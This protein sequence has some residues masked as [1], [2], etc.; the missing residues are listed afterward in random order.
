MRELGVAERDEVSFAIV[1]RR[2]SELVD[3]QGKV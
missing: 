2:G 3:D 1:S